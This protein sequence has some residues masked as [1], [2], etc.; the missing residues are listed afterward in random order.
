MLGC[1]MVL[2]P[3]ASFFIFFWGFFFVLAVTRLFTCTYTLLLKFLTIPKGIGMDMDGWAGKGLWSLFGLC[4][5][6]FW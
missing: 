5:F 1:L 4:L 6:V 3:M 2:I